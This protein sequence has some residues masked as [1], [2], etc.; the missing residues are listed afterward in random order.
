[1]SDVNIALLKNMVYLFFEP[2][3]RRMKAVIIAAGNGRRLRPFTEEIPKPLAPLGGVP[4]IERIVLSGKEA[5]IKEFLVVLG[6]LGDK[7]KEGLGDGKK[8]G[9]RIDYVKTGNGRGLT[10]FPYIR[11][12]RC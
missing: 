11:P 3:T 10:V 7:L 6:Y 4:L 12:G 2:R 8:H 5:G 1:M 9:V